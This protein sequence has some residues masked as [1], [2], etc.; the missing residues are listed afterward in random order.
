MY[1]HRGVKIFLGHHDCDNHG[2]LS[3]ARYPPRSDHSGSSFTL[4]SVLFFFLSAHAAPYCTPSP[5]YSFAAAS[6]LFLRFSRVACRS[7]TNVIGA[8]FATG[9][10]AAVR[11]TVKQ[12]YNAEVR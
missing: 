11:V 10:A 12:R 7:S 2:F 5:L 4:F 9:V 6:S 8:R 1:K 3:P